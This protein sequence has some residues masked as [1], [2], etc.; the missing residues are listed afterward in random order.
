MKKKVRRGAGDRKGVVH[1]GDR[2]G[3]DWN[4]MMTFLPF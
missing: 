2:T 3:A 1:V 4:G